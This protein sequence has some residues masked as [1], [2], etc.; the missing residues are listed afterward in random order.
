MV[1]VSK[2]GERLLKLREERNETQEQLAK[3][4][5]ITRQS[6]SRYETNERTPNI[7]LIFSVA[8][9]YKVSADYLL[10]LSDV[11][12]N[13]IGIR[14]ACEITGLTEASV[15][16][17][18]HVS[19]L[20]KHQSNVTLST[21]LNEFLCTREFIPLMHE[22]YTLYCR[23]SELTQKIIAHQTVSFDDALIQ[24]AD[25]QLFR[26]SERFRKILDGF[27]NPAYDKSIE[28][29]SKYE[30]WHIEDGIN[31]NF[32]FIPLTSPPVPLPDAAPE[33]IESYKK[34]KQFH[35]QTVEQA[36]KD[37]AEISLIYEEEASNNA[38]H[39]PT[40]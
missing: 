33:R 29:I 1:S 34:W 37:L 2:F 12:S 36:N 35:K 7:D 10:G 26:A 15:R 39:N 17:I 4:I 20:S 6:L 22:C 9:H 8:Q 28:Y 40:P 25:L 31:N 23:T 13:D 24:A 11:Q 18:Q 14:S 30:S 32:P 16:N 27:K 21:V 5:N 3:A 38:Q 19:A